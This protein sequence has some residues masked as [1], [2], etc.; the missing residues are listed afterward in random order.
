MNPRSAQSLLS[1]HFLLKPPA[2]GWPLSS[3]RPSGRP[4]A[5]FQQPWRGIL[6]RSRQL[7]SAANNLVIRGAIAPGTRG[8]TPIH[9]LFIGPPACEAAGGRAADN[10]QRLDP[11]NALKDRVSQCRGGANSPV[12]LRRSGTRSATPTSRPSGASCP[13]CST[14]P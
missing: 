14:S 13:I 6:A 10:A 4:L 11:A 3:A 8:L 2:H 12:R 5:D 7:E 1:R 9:A